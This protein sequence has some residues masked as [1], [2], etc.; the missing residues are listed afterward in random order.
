MKPGAIT[1]G[2][3]SL[4]VNVAKALPQNMR[5][6]VYEISNVRT[7]PQYRG[8]GE[9]TAL[10]LKTCNKADAAGKFLLVHVEPDSDS[11]V[12]TQGLVNFYGGFGF[13]PFQAS[14]ALLMVRPCGGGVNYAAS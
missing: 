11:P 7:A 4:V 14:P 12:D 10:L 2:K 13:K 1:H 8:Q 6:H 9:A 3:S 5:G